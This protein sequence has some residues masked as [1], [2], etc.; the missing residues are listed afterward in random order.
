M[1]HHYGG[2][3]ILMLFAFGSLAA[4]WAGSAAN[5][6][7]RPSLVAAGGAPASSANYSIQATVG[8]MGI[9]RGASANYALCS[10]FWC[11]VQSVLRQVFM[12][13]IRR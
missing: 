12:P 13:L 9:G 1:K 11:Q 4:A 8:Q 2:L 10:G 3:I 5:D 7:P 6:A